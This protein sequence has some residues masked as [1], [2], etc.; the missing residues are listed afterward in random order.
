MMALRRGRRRAGRSVDAPRARVGDAADRRVLD[1][2]LI[3]E[4]GAVGQLHPPVVARDEDLALARLDDG[5][6]DLMLDAVIGPAFDTTGECSEPHSCDGS[7]TVV[8]RT[9]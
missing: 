3:A 6:D 4:H 1:D 7:A 9:R 8:A 5:D 2:A